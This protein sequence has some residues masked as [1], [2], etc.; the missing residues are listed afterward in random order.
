MK[1]SNMWSR[2]NAKKDLKTVKAIMDRIGCKFFL[3]FGT[4][5]GALREGDFIKDDVD[6]D[7]GIIGDEH[8]NKIRNCLRR[9]GFTQNWNV[10]Q[11]VISAQRNV[12]FDFHFYVDEGETVLMAH[13]TGDVILYGYPKEFL[14]FKEIDFCGDKY[15]IPLQYDKYLKWVGYD[16]WRT[17]SNQHVSAYR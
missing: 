5:I 14:E 7:L 12:K 8:R 17:P 10:N 6:I 2:K 16:D 15:W 3:N 13:A 9:A 11:D 1:P 4:L